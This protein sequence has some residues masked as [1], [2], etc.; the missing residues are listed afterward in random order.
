MIKDTL[1]STQSL[2]KAIEEAK[3][4]HGSIGL[5]MEDYLERAIRE[6]NHQSKE[7]FPDSG[8]L[9]VFRGMIM[10][11]LTA[12]V[13]IEDDARDIPTSD[14]ASEYGINESFV[15]TLVDEAVFNAD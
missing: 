12:L 14:I 11:L 1:E 10:G 7:D 15:Y 5:L 8:Q 2:E 9:D 4:T 3:R 13:Y 6:R